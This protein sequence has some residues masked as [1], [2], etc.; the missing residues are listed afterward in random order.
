MPYS[1]GQSAEYHL[2]KLNL[3]SFRSSCIPTGVITI[4]RVLTWTSMIS[5]L[6]SRCI[7]FFFWYIHLLFA[8]SLS[9]FSFLTTKLF[10]SR[11]QWCAKR[12][13]H[14]CFSLISL[15]Y[16]GQMHILWSIFVSEFSF[17]YFRNGIYFAI[18]LN[19]NYVYYCK[20]DFAFLNFNI[21]NL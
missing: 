5:I 6:L 2:E 3:V 8:S 13:S 15:F 19:C 9:F 11:S 7:D 20:K 17:V 12:S 1:L 18:A 10:E 21:S 14:G 4:A 16:K